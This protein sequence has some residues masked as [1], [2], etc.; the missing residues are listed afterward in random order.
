MDLFYSYSYLLFSGRA[1]IPGFQIGRQ[2]FDKN[3]D[4]MQ[5]RN[6][7]GIYL[8]VAVWMVFRVQLN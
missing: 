3:D 5:K 4:A 1:P 8:A 7:I 2:K 6:S